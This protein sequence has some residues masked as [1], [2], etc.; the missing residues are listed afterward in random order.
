MFGYMQKKKADQIEKRDN[1]TGIPVQMKAYAENLYGS[2]LDNVRVHYHSEKPSQFNALGYT[3]GTN[4]YLGPGQEKHLMHELCHVIQ[5]KK[6]I[7]KPTSIEG[8]HAINDSRILEK[9][10]ES[11]EKQYEKEAPMQ[12]LRNMAEQGSETMGQPG[13]NSQYFGRYQVVARFTLKDS[14][15]NVLSEDSVWGYKA[16]FRNTKRNGTTLDLTSRSGTV[17]PRLDTN[18]E[19]EDSDGGDH[20]EDAICDYIESIDFANYLAKL[21]GKPKYIQLQGATL[22]IILSA[23]PCKR[24]QDRLK[25][26]AKTYGLKL[27]VTGARVY[28]GKKGGGAGNTQGYSIASTK[29]E[30]NKLLQF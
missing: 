20:A 27:N 15:G 23:S 14:G 22:E 17:Y 6:G 29:D 28:G 7:V 18:F 11:L 24:C 3:Q 4:V 10:A 21:E 8:G 16:S 13:L 30:K 12:M 9:E 5:Q 25:E 2:S 1:I 26:T 19:E